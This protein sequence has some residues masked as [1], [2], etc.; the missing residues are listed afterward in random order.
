[1]PDGVKDTRASI[2]YQTAFHGKPP[3][4]WTLTLNR[5]QRDNLLWLLNAIGY[6]WGQRVEPFNLANTGDW[7]GEIAQMLGKIH[8]LDSHAGVFVIDEADRPNLSLDGL[9]DRINEWVAHNE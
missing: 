7:V 4:T 6:P 3:E 2:A 8:L 1:M 9:K 5:Y